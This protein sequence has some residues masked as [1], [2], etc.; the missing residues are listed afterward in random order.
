M[1]KLHFLYIA[2]FIG[3]TTNIVALLN[4]PVQLRGH[5]EQLENAP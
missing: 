2:N 1:L 4:D 5:W 3:V